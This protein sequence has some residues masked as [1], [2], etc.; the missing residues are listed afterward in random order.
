MSSSDIDG[1]SAPAEILAVAG[2]SYAFGLRWTSVA[3]RGSLTAEALSA[4]QAEG[5]NYIAL[6]S[7][8]NQFGLARIPGAPDGWRSIAYRPLVGAA[9]IAAAVGTATLAAFPLEDG[10]W[11]VLAID[12]KGFLPDGDLIVA[13]AEQARARID[14]LVAQSPNSW[15]RKFLPADWKIAD[16]KSTSPQDLLGRT[17]GPHLSS[18]WLLKHRRLIGIAV[19]ACL[20]IAPA[21]LFFAVRAVSAP[22]PPFRGS[23]PA[24]SAG[25]GGLDACGPDHQS[26][27][28]G[29]PGRATLCGRPGLVPDQIHVPGG[30]RRLGELRPHRRRSDRRHP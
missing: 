23:V 10:R 13:D 28:V 7:T 29:I 21:I 19:G 12:R 9:A 8:F 15:R 6:N 22:P 1:R 5:A 17:G 25:S 18:R 3:T 27:P 4:A 16:S 14:A 26:V 30:P 24:A 11:L 20:A 2:K